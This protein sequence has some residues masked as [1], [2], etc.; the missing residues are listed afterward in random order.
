M[1]SP[2]L[3]IL[4]DGCVVG[5][6]YGDAAHLT[7][8]AATSEAAVLFCMLAGDVIQCRCPAGAAGIGSGGDGFD[9]GGLG[10]AQEGGSDLNDVLSGHCFR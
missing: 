5:K 1:R 3:V 8:S 7:G 10:K 2:L 9:D 6:G 4:L